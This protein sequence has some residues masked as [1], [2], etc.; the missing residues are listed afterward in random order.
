MIM[1]IFINDEPIVCQENS[2]ITSLLNQQN[3]APAYIAVALNE[4]VIP[5]TEWPN[6]HIPNGSRLIIIKAIQG[7]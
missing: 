1:Q 2:T 5:Q 4:T 6:T 7:G 3:I